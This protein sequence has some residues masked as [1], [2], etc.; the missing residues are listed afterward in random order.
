MWLSRE[1][2][3]GWQRGDPRSPDAAVALGVR[4]SQ[5]RQRH[6]R[7]T[8]VGLHLRRALQVGRP[9]VGEPAVEVLAQLRADGQA[10]PEHDAP[11]HA[12]QRR[13]LWRI[14]EQGGH[15]P[16][17]LG[18]WGGAQHGKGELLLARSGINVVGGGR[19]GDSHAVQL[20]PRG[21]V[22]EN[23]TTR[24]DVRRVAQVRNRDE[25]VFRQGVRR[26]RCGGHRNTRD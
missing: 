3:D 4:L 18:R 23:R 8:R 2:G 9:Q 5:K 17:A 14:G 19:P 6:R 26:P 24:S 15:G 10:L 22:V 7:D 13:V 12:E 16:P 21:V 25:T 20:Q 11:R 1:I